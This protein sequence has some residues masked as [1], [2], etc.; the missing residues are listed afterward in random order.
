MKEDGCYLG[1]RVVAHDKCV[2]WQ[3]KHYTKLKKKPMPSILSS[4]IL[5]IY[6]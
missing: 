1:S 4:H 3:K 6:T 2:F 5:N